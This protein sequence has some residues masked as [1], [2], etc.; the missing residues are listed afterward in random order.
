MLGAGL[1]PVLAAPKH[2]TSPEKLAAGLPVD[3]EY[4]EREGAVSPPPLF[5]WED[6]PPRLELF[7]NRVGIQPSTSALNSAASTV[8]GSLET[9][10][11][12]PP[13]RAARVAAGKKA[14]RP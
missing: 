2:K 12:R 1:S 10:P 9:Q 3:G 11:R 6:K 5:S 14:A 8:G 13:C 4:E 7:K